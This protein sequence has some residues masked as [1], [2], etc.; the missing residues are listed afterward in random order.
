MAKRGAY[1][2]Q[3]EKV[4]VTING[5]SKSIEKNDKPALKDAITKLSMEGVKSVSSKATPEAVLLMGAPVRA[6][7]RSS[8]EVVPDLS[9]FV[10][11]DPDAVKSAMPAYQEGI[12]A[13]N[14]DIASTV[15]G[16][17]KDIT[18]SIVNSS[19][20]TRRN[21]LYDGTGGNLQEYE[22]MINA[23]HKSSYH[24][25]LVMTHISVDEGLKRVAERAAITGRAIPDAV[26]KDM[27][28]WVPR[29]FPTLAQKADQAYLYD[30]MVPKGQSPKL[31][32]EK[33]DGVTLKDD[34]VVALKDLLTSI[35]SKTIDDSV[36]VDAL[37][38]VAPTGGDTEERQPFTLKGN[39][40]KKAKFKGFFGKASTFVK[41]QTELANYQSADGPAEK[42]AS[43][44]ILKDLA[45]HWLATHGAENNKDVVK[46]TSIK[47]LLEDIATETPLVNQQIQADA[48]EQD[49]YIRQIEAKSLK[50]MTQ[51]GHMIAKFMKGW[52]GGTDTMDAT[53]TAAV[54]ELTQTHGLT[55]AEASA[56][57]G[58]TRRTI[59]NT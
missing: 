15:H 11:A 9:S 48:D 32:W 55:L 16:E 10:H 18:K 12:K 52:H 53:R 23:L 28:Q 30:N 58:S 43:L 25:K 6:S 39:L 2:V 20:E 37:P 7:L 22:G 41:L 57:V 51:T 27:Y 3:R 56:I 19:I 47:K 42:L 13:G 40:S 34:Q 1:T 8:D 46:E 36:P 5:K 59:T 31:V 44:T 26:V 4:K 38:D 14:K 35:A 50:Y 45:S 21:L 54:Q 33:G 29:N 17:S 24:V 49:E